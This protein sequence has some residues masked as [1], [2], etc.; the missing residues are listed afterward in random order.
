LIPHKT[1]WNEAASSIPQMGYQAKKENDYLLISLKSQAEFYFSRQNLSRDYFLQQ[2][3]ASSKHLGAVPASI[4]TKFPKMKEIYS[5]M[6]VLHGYHDKSSDIDFLYVALK[7]SDVVSMSPCRK[8]L[9]PH[10]VPDFEPNHSSF[11][12]KVSAKS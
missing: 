12:E 9:I 4:V 7:G 3:L 11:L 6:R 2:L 8:F 10:N 1:L 5:N